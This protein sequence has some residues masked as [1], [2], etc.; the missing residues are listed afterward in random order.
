MDGERS[1]MTF[2]LEIFG[3]D[4]EAFE[5]ANIIIHM[6]GFWDDLVDK[7]TDITEDEINRSMFMALSSIHTNAFF[8]QHARDLVPLMSMSSMNYL[9]ARTW[10]RS[11]DP[12]G[13]E[14]AHVFRYW[15]VTVIGAI[16]TQC[17]G[18]INALEI[19]PDLYK[20]MCS[21]R[22]HQYLTDLTGES[23]AQ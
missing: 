1:A 22:F 12:H 19:L 3:G 23:D 17:L 10:E 8:Q 6:G 4:E 9:V 21:E 2:G 5:L 7:D 11:R 15:V 18:P 20:A 16:V 14:L 13:L